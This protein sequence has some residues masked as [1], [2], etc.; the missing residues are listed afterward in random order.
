ME[1][2]RKGEWELTGNFMVTSSGDPRILD[3]DF[4]LTGAWPPDWRVGV[5]VG[6]GE[7]TSQREG[8]QE[9]EKGENGGVELAENQMILGPSCRS[10]SLGSEEMGPRFAWVHLFCMSSVSFVYF[11]N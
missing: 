10:T 2:S 9:V 8:N 4:R 6:W 7:S 3:C 11:F 5:L 1:K